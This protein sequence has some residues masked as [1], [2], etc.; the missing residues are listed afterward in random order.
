MD[1]W[2][3]PNSGG[4]ITQD[5]DAS[6]C[7][8]VHGIAKE[9]LHHRA[10][11]TAWNYSNKKREK[12]SLFDLMFLLKKWPSKSFLLIL[13]YFFL[14][15]ILRNYQRYDTENGLLIKISLSTFCIQDFLPCC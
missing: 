7:P 2:Q 4:F 8:F 14:N 3:K 10:T 11:D 15:L 13:N 5:G 12:L 1:L 9:K 6:F